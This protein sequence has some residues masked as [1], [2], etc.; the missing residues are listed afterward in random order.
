[1]A[2][3]E[4]AGAEEGGGEE[5]GSSCCSTVTLCLRSNREQYIV[6]EYIYQGLD[7]IWRG[8]EKCGVTAWQACPTRGSENEY[9]RRDGRTGGWFEMESVVDAANPRGSEGVGRGRDSGRLL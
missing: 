3:G 2:G 5:R 1:M 7:K 9:G 4:G 6:I 8:P